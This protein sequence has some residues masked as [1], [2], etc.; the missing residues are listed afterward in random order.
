MKIPYEEIARSAEFPGALF[1]DITSAIFL[2]DGDCRLRA[3]NDPFRALFHKPE[4]KIIGELCG[5][6]LGC[7]HVNGNNDCGTTV[8]C[9]DCGLRKGIL[10]T[11]HEGIRFTRHKIS[12][13]FYIRGKPVLKY[14]HYSTRPITLNNQRLVMFILDDITQEEWQQIKIQ[15]QNKQLELERIN[16]NALVRMAV[17]NLVTPLLN[18]QSL[19]ER[20]GGKE[21]IPSK[22]KEKTIEKIQALSKFAGGRLKVIQA[23]AERESSTCLTTDKQVDIIQIVSDTVS[24]S[25]GTTVHDNITIKT[26]LPGYPVFMDVDIS[27]VRL[28][29]DILIENAKMRSRE[30]G[31][32]EVGA[33]LEGDHIKIWVWDKGP[34]L[35]AQEQEGMLYLTEDHTDMEGHHTPEKTGALILARQLAED[36]GG[37][38]GIDSP[39]GSG[40]RF[41][42]SLSLS[43]KYSAL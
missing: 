3:I 40:V 1:N 2:A 32:I 19:A 7:K 8:D 22:E 16:R 27:R 42:F 38:M 24:L 12:R 25:R 39:E 33:T 41:W 28:I 20:L 23:Y 6:V 9:H 34:A 15:E 11:F 30:D 36:H 13:T 4:D 14:F 35:S 29:T 37:K 31:D 5:N 10:R 26:A 21:I 43:H 17:K 18:I